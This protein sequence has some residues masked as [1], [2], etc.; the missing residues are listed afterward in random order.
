MEVVLV[1]RA[2]HSLAVALRKRVNVYMF[3]PERRD[4]S[5]HNVTFPVT[6]ESGEEGGLAGV[7]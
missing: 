7:A 6:T 3:T 2:S 5:R 1:V 4:F